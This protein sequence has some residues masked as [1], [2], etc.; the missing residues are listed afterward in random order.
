[1]TELIVALDEPTFDQAM[2]VVRRTSAR[3]SWYKVGYEAYYGYGAQILGALREAEKSVFLDLKLHDIPTTVAAAVRAVARLGARLVTV[4][5]AG[6]A[7]MLSAAAGARDESPSG[8]RLLAVT[9]L[10][11]MSADDLRATG[12][13]RPPNELVTLRA[14]LAAQCRID[15]VVCAVSEAGAVRAALGLDF[16]VLCPGI[17]PESAQAGDHQRVATPAEA[18]RAGADF[19]VV[20][21]PI[22]RSA[23]PASAARAILDELKTAS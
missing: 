20:G 7:A 9:V 12:V 19:I 10:T 4:H 1:M 22:T 16:L 23:D 21:R 13:D 17:R 15:G 6:G 11:S 8:P 2:D 3:V 18:V 14:R 5:A